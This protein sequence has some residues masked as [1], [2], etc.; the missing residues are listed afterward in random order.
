MYLFVERK[1][2]DLNLKLRVLLKEIKDLNKKGFM[3]VNAKEDEP[4]SSLVMAFQKVKIFEKKEEEE[5][6]EIS[7]NNEKIFSYYHFIFNIVADLYSCWSIYNYPKGFK[8]NYNYL[9]YLCKDAFE[10]SK[11]NINWLIWL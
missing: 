4:T 6:K 7:C 11:M 10:R 3:R 5:K 2:K 1:K 8:F 9:Y